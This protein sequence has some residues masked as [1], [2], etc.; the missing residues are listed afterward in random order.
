MWMTIKMCVKF[1]LAYIK[2]IWY[3]LKQRVRA[4]FNQ[5]ISLFNFIKSLFKLPFEAWYLAR[6]DYQEDYL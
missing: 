1:S 2:Y 6:I 5:E 4:L 3:G